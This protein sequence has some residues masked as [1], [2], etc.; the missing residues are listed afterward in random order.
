M[1]A[2]MA[3]ASSARKIRRMSMKN[4]GRTQ[5][6]GRETERDRDRERERKRDRE[7]GRQKVRETEG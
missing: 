4:C 2:R 7:L 6:H 5:R 3:A 1:K